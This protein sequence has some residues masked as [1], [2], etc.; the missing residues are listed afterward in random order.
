MSN[1]NTRNDNILTWTLPTGI[2]A[3]KEADKDFRSVWFVDEAY[4]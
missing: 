4:G 3:D 1:D 2:A